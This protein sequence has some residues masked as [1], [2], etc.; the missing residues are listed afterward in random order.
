M[1]LYLAK[2]PFILPDPT[3]IPALLKSFA[4]SPPG[5]IYHF[6]SMFSQHFIHIAIV[7]VTMFYD[8]WFYMCHSLSLDCELPGD[9]DHLSPSCRLLSIQHIICTSLVGKSQVDGLERCLTWNS[10]PRVLLC[11]I[12]TFSFSKPAFSS[13]SEDS[14][15]NAQCSCC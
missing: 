6:S 2:I 1:L 7:A 12:V 11:S 15:T 4:P 10:K 5:A 14:M 9:G 3:Q 13:D 8:A